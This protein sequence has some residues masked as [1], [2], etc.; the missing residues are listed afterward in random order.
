M[1]L[2]QYEV[3]N[4]RS[5]RDRQTL[6]LVAS[7]YYQEQS[8]SLITPKLPGLSG[9][10]LL[11]IEVVMGANA[12]GKSTLI[13]SL[14]VLRGMVLKSFT[15]PAGRALEYDPFL[16]SAEA[17]SS[18]TSFGLIFT[19]RGVRYEYDLSYVEDHIVREAL[20]AY[21]KGREQ[22][23]FVRTWNE[24]EE[25]V[26]FAHLNA[27]YVKLPKDL[28][29]MLRDDS[30]FLSFASLLNLESLKPVVEWFDKEHLIAANRSIDGPKIRPTKAFS[31]I[32][33]SGD[34]R[35]RQQFIGLLRDADFGIKDVRVV[36]DDKPLP[37]KLKDMFNPSVFEQIKEVPQKT[38]MFAHSAEDSREVELEF[39]DESAGTKRFFELS[40]SLLTA[41]KNGGLV[42]IDELDASLHPIL[43]KELVSLFR[44]KRSNPYGAQLVFS[45]HDV[46]LLDEGLLRRDEIWLTEKDQS[47]GTVLYP[48]SDYSPRNDE[49]LMGGYLVGRYGG[50]PVIPEPMSNYG[51]NYTGE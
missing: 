43:L 5:I 18:P 46:T 40:P 38:A 19:S 16:L 49:A 31:L 8:E 10:D 29:D 28:E 2:I 11:P 24:E 47:G 22:K 30:L 25:K 26:K 7:N 36:E 17:A 34:A 1:M 23:W 51:E 9:V 44:D 33:Q 37:E 3:E 35:D 6:S 41:L 45:A 32:E 15:N 27:S 50:V 21:P 20:S 4:Y 48:L 42:F 12:S 13:N 14:F 39:R